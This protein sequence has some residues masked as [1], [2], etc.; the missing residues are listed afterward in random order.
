AAR[1][2]SNFPS[3]VSRCTSSNEAR[4]G[5]D[6]AKPRGHRREKS[7]VEP[8]ARRLKREEN[9]GIG[10][11]IRS[12][13]ELSKG[14]LVPL[15]H[16]ASTFPPATLSQKERLIKHKKRR[17]GGPAVSEVQGGPRK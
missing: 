16:A 11:R 7:R 14:M 12:E 13:R 1:A 8:Q 10:S 2:S 4:E 6:W 3:S 17:A 5:A 15:S 9:C